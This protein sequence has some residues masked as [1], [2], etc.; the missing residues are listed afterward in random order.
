MD[1]RA[2]Y[3]S[4]IILFR[5]PPRPEVEA[6]RSPHGLLHPAF[7]FSLSAALTR[8]L[9]HL[10]TRWD[11]LV[12]NITNDELRR[13]V[14]VASSVYFSSYSHFLGVF[15]TTGALFIAQYFP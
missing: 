10:D 2:N 12:S 5:T 11:A 4:T 8:L 1:P 13:A 9:E 6:S 3:A 14:L 15:D 7:L